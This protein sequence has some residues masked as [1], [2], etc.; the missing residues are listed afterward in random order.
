MKYLFVLWFSLISISSYAVEYE[1]FTEPEREIKV[2]APELGILQKIAVK[3]G[4]RVKKGQ[5]LATLETQVLDA[6][7]TVAKAKMNAQGRLKSAQSI[8]KL[9]KDKLNRLLP[10][11]SQG[12]AQQYEVTQAQ[13]ELEAAAAEV[14]AARDALNISSLEYKQIQ[15]QIAHRQIYSPIS[16]VVT[17]IVKEV[18]EIVGGNDFHVMTIAVLD[19][20]TVIIRVPTAQALAL[21][22]NQAVTV[23]FPAVDLSMLKAKIAT[24]SPIT[25]ASSDTVKVEINL[26]NGKGKLRSGLKCLVKIGE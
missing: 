11:L 19:K 20:L 26:D 3:E 23:S 7:L 10:L 1:G 24:I 9:R 13:I 12:N 2:A 16:G 17:D 22:T 6:A 25:D 18:A 5:L 4:N 14:T 8:E 21:K 15:A